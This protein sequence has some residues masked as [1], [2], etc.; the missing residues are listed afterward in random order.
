VFYYVGGLRVCGVEEDG[1][2][3]ECGE[4]RNIRD[5]E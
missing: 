1:G 3:F 4:T 2:G 5:G